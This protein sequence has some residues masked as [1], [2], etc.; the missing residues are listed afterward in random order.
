VGEKGGVME[1]RADIIV[2]GSGA[3][4]VHA[5]FPLVQAGR[6]VIM[7]DVG[8]DDQRYRA[9]IPP[10]PFAEIRRTDTAQHRY[11]LGEDFE[12]VPLGQMGAGPQITPPRQYVLRDSNR[13]GLTQSGEF[14]ALES[15]ALGGLAQ[16][17]GAGSFPF[18][19]TELRRCGLPVRELREHY[20]IVARRIGVTGGRDDLTP[21]FGIL[22]A[23]QPP[24]DLDQNAAR[25]I[26]RYE[27]LRNQLRERR[28]A[29][30]R[31]MLAVLTQPLGNRGANP[32]R[33][34]DFWTNPADSVYRPDLTLCEL[35]RYNNFHYLH[36]F[37][38]EEFAEQADG[39]LTVQAIALSDKQR[40][41]FRAQRLVLGAGSF[42]TTR[43]VLRSLRKYDVPVPITCNPHGYVPCL[44]WRGLGQ[45][46]ADRCHS[47]AQ[48]TMIYDRTADFEHLVQAQ[49]FSYRSL[50]LFRLIK[51]L[52]L[53]YREGLRVMHALSSAFVI[54]VVQ[55]EDERTSGKTCVL[56]RGDHDGVDTLEVNYRL[57][58]AEEQVCR[59][60]EEKLMRTFLQL[61]CLPL[62]RVNPGLGSSVHYG[63]QLPFSTEDKPLTAELSGRLRGTRGVYIADGATFSYLPAKGLT[64]TLMANANRIGTAVLLT[65][66]GQGHC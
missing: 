41:L 47:L 33:D 18:L 29:V 62:K 23:L 50:L 54:W 21:L 60:N 32:Y 39:D 45:P 20:E 59:D 53:S 28:I 49:M 30:G 42:G 40:V 12:G 7:L 10:K 31:T 36:P 15:F 56:R 26:L 52:P 4:A 43:I 19:D 8:H 64:F 63:S 66:S 17:W 48:L 61:G 14:A 37:L 55:H 24:L 38:V 51:E 27:Q 13:L 25:I 2:V 65:L 57:T 6:S 35:R 11:F 46:P 9:L 34:M 22:N 5:A 3:S 16:A 58:K 44:N 1:R